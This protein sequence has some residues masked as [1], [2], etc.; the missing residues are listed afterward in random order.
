MLGDC[1]LINELEFFKKNGYVHLKR[2]FPKRTIS[3]VLNSAATIF[4]RQSDLPYH[5]C[6]ED[7][8]T[9]MFDLFQ[10]DRQT[11]IN[12]G[13]AC[14]NTIPLHRLGIDGN[15]LGKIFDLGIT[16][17]NISTRPVLFFNSKRLATK[18]VYYKTPAHQDWRSI[19]GSQNSIVLWVP[20]VDVTKDLGA[21]EIIP[22]SHLWGLRSE[23]MEDG[24]GVVDDVYDEEFTSVEVEAGDALFF[25][26]LLVHRSGEN[27]TDRVRWSCHFRYND[28]L[29]PSYLER[30]YPSPYT[31]KPDPKLITEGFPTA[32][33][34]DALYKSVK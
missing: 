7:V 18:D 28:L 32:D 14:Q 11:F 13:K 23:R 20:L 6:I 24:F 19:Q 31:Y 33:Q 5:E 22:G 30:G 12:C 1:V 8:E 26:T 34:M 15:V 2:F 27:S 10:N 25:S 29:D 3:G 17:P 21:L 16:A 4:R 9:E